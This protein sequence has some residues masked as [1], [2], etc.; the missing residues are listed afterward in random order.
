M[1]TI[2]YT[3]LQYGNSVIPTT[4]FMVCNLLHSNLQRNVF[5]TFVSALIL[6]LRFYS[7]QM[8]VD[9]KLR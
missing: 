9:W 5:L 4:K 7:A 2:Q 1:V 8:E 6:R 3:L